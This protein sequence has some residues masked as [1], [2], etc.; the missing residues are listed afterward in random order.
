MKKIKKNGLDLLIGIAFLTDILL[1][2][3][4]LSGKFSNLGAPGTWLVGISNFIAVIYASKQFKENKSEN[5]KSMEPLVF[6][7]SSDKLLTFIWNTNNPGNDQLNLANY[8]KT[9][10]LFTFTNVGMN[11]AK[12]VKLFNDINYN[13]TSLETICDNPDLQVTYINPKK[14]DDYLFDINDKFNGL[15]TSNKFKIDSQPFIFSKKSITFQLPTAYLL[16]ILAK[17]LKYYSNRPMLNEDT[18]KLDIPG[19]KISIQYKDLYDNL[20]RKDFILQIRITGL[21][22]DYDME[23]KQDYFQGE[24]TFTMN[25]NEINNK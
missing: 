8:L 9:P 1:L 3:L 21:Y 13:R 16:A 5:Q 15:M 25:M 19:W 17:T 12:D 4:S 6:A 20:Y 23:K 10:I 14:F 7:D 11:T 24:I 18:K 2:I 22:R